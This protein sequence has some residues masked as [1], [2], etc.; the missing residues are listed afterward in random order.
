MNKELINVL[1]NGVKPAL[2]CTEPV[3]VG[4]AV[5]RAREAETGKV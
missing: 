4:L 3:A 5:A 1:K 2:G